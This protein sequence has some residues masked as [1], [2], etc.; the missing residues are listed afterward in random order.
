[1]KALTFLFIS[2]LLAMTFGCSPSSDSESHS[3]ADA[4]PLLRHVVLF[5]FKDS[6][7]PMQVKAIEEAFRQLPKQIPEVVDFE[8]G[9]DVSIEGKSHDFTHCF[10]VS[11]ADDAGRAAY[12][13]HPAHKAF[14]ELLMPSLDKVTVVDFYGHDI[15]G[16]KEVGGQLR[17]VVMFQFK[18]GTSA[19]DLKAIETK[20]ASLPGDIPTV[21][22]FEW[23]TNNSPEGLADGYSHCFLV[24]FKNESGREVYAPHP[25]HK[26][27]GTIVRPHVEKVLVVDYFAKE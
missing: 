8:W 24:T 21:T 22:A 26:E 3:A 18:D 4:K 9:T 27:F 10:L 2:T 14:V 7:S 20:F 25:S 16:A 17:H 5:K 11:F 13:P 1:M 23:G 12:I 6:A 15:Q 19:G